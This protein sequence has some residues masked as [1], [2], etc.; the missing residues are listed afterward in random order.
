[1]GTLQMASI[2]ISYRHVEPDQSVARALYRHLDNLDHDVFIDEQD[3]PVG[4]FWAK[5]IWANI[6]RTEW[7][8]SLISSTYL[9]DRDT[10]TELQLASE[11]LK[12]DK[13]KTILPI[14]IQY[15]GRPPDAVREIVQEI[16]FLKWQGPDDT[17]EILRQV[18]NRIPPA[19]LLVKGMKS[20]D[21]SDSERFPK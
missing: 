15:A 20:F 6:R 3:I 1:M 19:D 12:H 5:E 17:Q 7:F 2:F 18:A 16:Q 9:S 4:N 8:I 10:L 21:I 11:C 13:P 14:N